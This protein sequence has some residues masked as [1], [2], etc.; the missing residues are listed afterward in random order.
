[1]TFRPSPLS[2][3]VTEIHHVPAGS[4]CPFPP[5]PYCEP[6]P[7]IE[8]GS[9]VTFCDRY[10]FVSVLVDGRASREG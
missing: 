2:I 6:P 5:R 7:L 8:N 10:E 4:L 3:T 9:I 1:L